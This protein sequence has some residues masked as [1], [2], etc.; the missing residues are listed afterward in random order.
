MFK[1]PATLPIAAL[2]LLVTLTGCTPEAATPAPESDSET[3]IRELE[4]DATPDW[5]IDASVVGKPVAADGVI[6][7]YTKASSGSLQIAA[8][9]STTGEALW[10][11]TAV[12]GAV[13]PGV[14]VSANIVEDG[15]KNLA[16]YLRPGNEEGW[17][18]LVLADLATGAP[19]ALTGNRVWA[20]SRPR[21]CADDRDICFTGYQDGA[22][23]DGIMNYRFAASG[24]D[25]T[26]DGDIV[27]PASARLLG[28]RVYATNAR[29]P[30]GT[31][32]L[33]AS[34]GGRTLW[35]RTYA[36][37]FG[38]GASSD[39]G[40]GW[41]DAHDA[42]V[43][44]G[45]GYVVDA[46][47]RAD[48]SS[49]SDATQRR[50]VGLDPETGETR[51]SI[52]GADFCDLSVREEERVDGKYTLCVYNA[53]T[54]TVAE[55]ADGT[56]Y[57]S[58]RTDFDVDLI[59][60][61]D[62]TGDVNW[63]LPLGGDRFNG[64]NTRTTFASSSAEQVMLIDGESVVVNIVTGDRITSSPESSYACSAE[65]EP[66]LAPSPGETETS[67]FSAGSDYEGCDASGTVTDGFSVG[68]VRMIGVDAGNGTVVVTAPGNLLGFSLDD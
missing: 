6:L 26:R 29:A 51:W 56:G 67:R 28:N 59:G 40:W 53:G 14:Q 4:T 33:G 50:V 43:M 18:D 22:V 61:D 42:K 2:A 38:D 20:T 68:A 34:A 46:D 11:D 3:T 25:I 52:D 32:L 23:D 58:I 60:V 37:V 66:L 21:A 1:I 62:F 65:R 39:G 8:W 63:T 55:K 44:V 54:T 16:V 13:T 17:Q 64:D 19:V 31:E 49:T 48:G 7:A 35:E 5:T 24:G 15:D 9:D 12:T 30:G 27:L 47:E 57:E 36:D 10:A 45:V 41:A